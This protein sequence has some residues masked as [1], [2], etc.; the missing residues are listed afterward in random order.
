MHAMYYDYTCPFNLPSNCPRYLPTHSMSFCFSFSFVYI[1]VFCLHLCMCAMYIQCSW[2]SESFWFLK[3][4]VTDCCEPSGG[5]LKMNS[6]HLEDQSMLLTT[7]T[8]S[9]ESFLFSLCLKC[10]PLYLISDTQS[11]CVLHDIADLTWNND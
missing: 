11:A 2:R 7:E 4:G 6:G 1:W 3:T 9:L 10:I 5:C 8:L